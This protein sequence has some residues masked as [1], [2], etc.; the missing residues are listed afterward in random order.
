MRPS[1]AIAL[2]GRPT[3]AAG[4]QRSRSTMSSALKP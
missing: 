3:V 2:M 1:V 4:S